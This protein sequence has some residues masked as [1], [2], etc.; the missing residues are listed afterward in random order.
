MGI[1]GET[2]HLSMATTTKE[3][4]AF[5]FS[6]NITTIIFIMGLDPTNLT[7]RPMHSEGGSLLDSLV[8]AHAHV[9]NTLCQ[10][11]FVMTFII[12][13]T[14]LSSM[15]IFLIWNSCSSIA[16]LIQ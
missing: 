4:R 13:S 6:K 9:L 12:I 15:W 11:S 2:N 10:F 5:P 8:G 14:I 1:G 7:F 3:E 16:F